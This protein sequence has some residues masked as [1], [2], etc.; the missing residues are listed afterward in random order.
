MSSKN[1][2]PLTI[3]LIVAVDETGGIGQT[4]L[5]DGSLPW[6]LPQEF[7][8]FLSLATDLQVLSRFAYFFQLKIAYEMMIIYNS[9]V[10]SFI[11]KLFFTLCRS[12]F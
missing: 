4:H 6:K 8:R 12:L 7:Q 3:N 9:T 2:L 5:E 1:H 10:K 11:N